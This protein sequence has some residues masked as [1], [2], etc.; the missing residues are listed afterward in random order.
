[1]QNPSSLQMLPSSLAHV[2]Q[3]FLSPLLVIDEL[4]S[5]EHA[6]P[7]V[8]DVPQRCYVG[9][10]A[11]T[12]R[13]AVRNT[14][15]CIGIDFDLDRRLAIVAAHH[16][17][18]PNW[19]REV[20]AMRNVVHRCDFRSV[21]EKAAHSIPPCNLHP[22]SGQ[23]VASLIYSAAHPHSE[24]AE[25]PSSSSMRW[26]VRSL[27]HLLPSPSSTTTS[28]VERCGRCCS[29]ALVI[30]NLR[31]A[32]RAMCKPKVIRPLGATFCTNEI[33]AITGKIAGCR[34]VN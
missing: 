31:A 26:L 1:M 4:L 15:L 2:A 23:Y 21:A 9:G 34:L 22:Q 28:A 14:E 24:Q 19:C 7:D 5:T 30:D 13:R 25:R 20:I 33:I 10:H 32:F 27:T 12:D 18:S 8:F 17:H 6:V 29:L 3:V 11:A 16:G